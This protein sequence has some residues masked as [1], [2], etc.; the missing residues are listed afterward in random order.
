MGSSPPPVGRTRC[1]PCSSH[2]RTSRPQTAGLR[3]SSGRL[4]CCRGVLSVAETS[5]FT[6]ILFTKDNKVRLLLVVH[7]CKL[8]CLQVKET[9]NDPCVMRHARCK[10]DLCG[11]LP[12]VQLK[13]ALPPGSVTTSFWSTP[14]VGRDRQSQPSGTVSS[15]CLTLLRSPVMLL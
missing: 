3:R 6:N 4:V 11:P 13:E 2:T 12:C 10:G 9:G 7:V 8:V 1:S 15:P 14:Q 5:S